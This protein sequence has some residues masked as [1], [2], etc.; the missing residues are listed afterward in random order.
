MDHGAYWQ[1]LGLGAG[2]ILAIGAQNA[3][4]LAHGVRGRNVLAVAGVCTLCDATLIAAGVLGLG[5]ALAAHP[6]LS[7]GALWGGA[8]F[9]AWFGAGSLRAA[10]GREALAPGRD[11]PDSLGRAVAGALAV[12][13]LNP[14]AVLDTVVLLGAASCAFPGAGRVSFGAGAATASGLWFFSLALFGRALA[15]LFADPRAWRVLHAL[16][17]LT[18]WTVALGLVRQAL[19]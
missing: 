18:V 4:V 11:T 14:H 3:F 12:S 7:R 17:A 19:A 15:P 13:L 10:L 9:L 1:G 5:Q 6:L 8:A 2:L 16:V